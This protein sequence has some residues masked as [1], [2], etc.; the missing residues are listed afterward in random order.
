MSRTLQAKFN[1]CCLVRQVARGQWGKA[2]FHL[3]GLVHAL[4]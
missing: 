3:T 1:L 4:S 2:K